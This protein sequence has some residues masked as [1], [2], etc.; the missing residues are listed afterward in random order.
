MDLTAL[1]DR[2]E[3]MLLIGVLNG[4]IYGLMALG[5]A[6]VYRGTRT[7]NFAQGELGT[8]SLF[9]AWWL[10]TDLGLP[11]FIGALGA[12]ALAGGVGVGFER[13]V[14]RSMVQA[15]RSTVTVATIGLLTLLLAFE[16]KFFGA[17]PRHV[18]APIGGRGIEIFDVFVSPTQMLSFVVL[19]G[20]AIG[21]GAALRRTDFGLGVLAAA[22]DPDATRLVGVPL[23]RVTAFVWGLGAVLAAVA[24]L[25][26]E[27]TIG[28][29]AP[30]FATL[31]FVKAIIAAVVG[32]LSNLNGAVV[33]GIV[34]G[35]VEQAI[36]DV[37][38]GAA[39]Q[40]AS[41][42][43]LV[44]MVLLVLLVL[45]GGIFAASRTRAAA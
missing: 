8:L 44:V 33:G 43:G 38:A 7:I 9:A 10:S 40:N 24:A 21:L 36:N 28:T 20:S 3:Q 2:P 5:I 45:P 13:V 11:W 23:A 22:Q 31:L 25:L 26:N 6:L 34:V 32:G 16:L 4:V 27:P 42:V 30:G 41:L 17:S 19:A 37:F 1:F 35:V 12:L 39:F 15:S 14:V 29:F 18:D